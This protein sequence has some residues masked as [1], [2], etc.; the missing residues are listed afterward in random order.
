[1]VQVHYYEDGNV[2]LQTS[3]EINE[4]ISVGVSFLNFLKFSPR[5]VY[6]GAGTSCRLVGR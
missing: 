5:L 6:W 2:Q 4:S 1:M 3:K